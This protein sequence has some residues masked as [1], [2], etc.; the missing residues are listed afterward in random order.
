[1]YVQIEDT[2]KYKYSS[3]T[4]TYSLHNRHIGSP[5]GK[6]ELSFQLYFQCYGTVAYFCAYFYIITAGDGYFR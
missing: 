5:R 1:M 3:Y 6:L 2:L 4:N